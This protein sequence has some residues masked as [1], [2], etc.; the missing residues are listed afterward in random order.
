MATNPDFRDLLS[1][2]SVEG[3][4]FIIVGAHAVMFHTLPRCQR[5]PPS[6]G[7]RGLHTAK[8]CC[9]LVV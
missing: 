5:K 8:R 6:T 4:E 1:A 2:L 3:S 7:R 9:S